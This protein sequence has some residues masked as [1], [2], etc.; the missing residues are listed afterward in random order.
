MKLSAADWIDHPDRYLLQLAG[1]P[2]YNTT[3]S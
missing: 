3:A 1:R 2:E